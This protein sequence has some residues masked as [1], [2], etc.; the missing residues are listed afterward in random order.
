MVE[1][2]GG[3]P[4][5]VD[6][7]WGVLPGAPVVMPLLIDRSG[8]LAAVEADEIGLASSA[9]GAGRIRK[10]DRIDPSVGIVMRPKVGD[11][12]ETGDRIGEIHARDE[13]AAA[14]AARRVLAAL[15]LADSPIEPR[16]LLYGWYA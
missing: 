10:G 3:D 11:R 15:T 8:V 9:L 16:P 2:Q 14:G 5:V 6:E 4:R 1:A 13:S 7:P 12:L